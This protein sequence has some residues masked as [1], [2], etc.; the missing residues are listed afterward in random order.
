LHA[1]WTE[2]KNLFS[3]EVALSGCKI[4]LS[5][6]GGSYGPETLTI[7][8]MTED[9]GPPPARAWTW[10]P[11][12]A[13]WHL[14]VADLV[15]QLDGQEHHGATLDDAIAVMSIIDEAYRS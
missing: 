12:D 7:H 8:E 2:W 5:G 4:E 14:E 9:L 3:L 11:G 1:S 10:P 13:S 15:A 6:L